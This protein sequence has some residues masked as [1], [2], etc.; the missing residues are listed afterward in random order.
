M[1]KFSRYKFVGFDVG[2]HG[3]IAK[4]GKIL[5]DCAG[6]PVQFFESSVE[7]MIEQLNHVFVA[8]DSMDLEKT[9]YGVVVCDDVI[10]SESGPVK[11]AEVLAGDQS[12]PIM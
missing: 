6:K 7:D 12:R 4:D 8:F 9:H 5:T 2:N 3:Y 11:E 10:M 1:Q